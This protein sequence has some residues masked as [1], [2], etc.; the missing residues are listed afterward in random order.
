[1]GYDEYI[2]YLDN[3]INAAKEKEANQIDP[4]T[5]YPRI[6]MDLH[7]VTS[8]NRDYLSFD[9]DF[10]YDDKETSYGVYGNFTLDYLQNTEQKE[11]LISKTIE[12]FF[13]A[14][15]SK[16]KPLSQPSIIDSREMTEL[17]N[18]RSGL[19]VSAIP[20]KDYSFVMRIRNTVYD[21][22]PTWDFNEDLTKKISGDTK[23]NTYWQ[24]YSPD[25]KNILFANEKTPA[26]LY[27]NEQNSST[28]RLLY[29]YPGV[30]TMLNFY[31]DGEPYLIDSENRRIVLP[32]QGDKETEYMPY[33]IESPHIIAG[34]D[35]TFIFRKTS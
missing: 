14:V 8:Y 15:N 4:N 2:A 16:E 35:D 22:S 3:Q 27:M 28:K 20:R 33:P 5:C 23:Y 34:S 32:Q 11:A 31:N 17:G 18:T 10:Y 21:V 6:Q 24:L 26:V 13:P 25:G 1:M 12:A 29:K 9:A 30:G 7:P 19:A